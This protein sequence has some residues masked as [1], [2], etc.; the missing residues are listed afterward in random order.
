MRI[1]SFLLC[2]LL[3]GSCSEHKQEDSNFELIDLSVFNGWTDYY[4]FKVYND[5]LTFL[6]IDRYKQGES[7]SK[8]EI[9]QNDLDSINSFLANILTSKIDTLYETNCHDCVIYNLIIKTKSGT[10]KSFVNGVSG[11][12]KEIVPMNVLVE[13]LSNIDYNLKTTLDTIIVFESR[14]G[15][16]FPVPQPLESDV[17]FTIPS[18][19]DTIQ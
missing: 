3:L 15:L 4:C 5:G 18:V 7:Y 13:Y 12:N 10:F 1:I 16:F 6:Y 14:T 17:R 2:F 9:G 19:E 11:N 8:I